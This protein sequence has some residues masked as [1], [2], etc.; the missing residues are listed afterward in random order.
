MND[1]EILRSALEYAKKTGFVLNKNKRQLDYVIKGLKANEDRHGFRF[2][3]CRVVTGN[4]EKD[5]K[6]ICPCIYH[7]QE[8]KESGHCL[9]RLFFSN[10]H[11]KFNQ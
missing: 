3:V 9:C 4:F 11:A 1:K 8:I 7:K 10:N 6:I 2:C 5:K